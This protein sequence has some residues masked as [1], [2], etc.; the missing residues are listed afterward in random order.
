MIERIY[1][2]ATSQHVGKTTTTLGLVNTLRKQNIN[3]GYCKV[4]VR[5]TAYCSAP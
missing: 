3:V 1:V 5:A 4:S 2:A